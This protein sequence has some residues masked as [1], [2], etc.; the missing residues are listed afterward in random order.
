MDTNKPNAHPPIDTAA[1]AKEFT[2]S[3]QGKLSD[4]QIAAA[5][6]VIQTTTTGYP[7]TGNVAS[8]V[9]YLQFQVDITGGKEFNGKGGGISTP[10]GGALFGTV[11]TDDL[12]RLYS[13]TVSFQFTAVAFVY[14]SIIFFDGNSNALG[15]FQAG[16]VS[17]VN[18]TGGGSGKW[19]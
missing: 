10:G 3:M 7:A 5:S 13:D 15:T 14:L 16:G 19:K 6:K 4:E 9:F 18:G 12:N 1:V 2:A 8:L 17:T 11:Y